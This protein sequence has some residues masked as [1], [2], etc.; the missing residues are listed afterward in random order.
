MRLSRSVT[1][2]FAV[3]IGWTFAVAGTA[4][5]GTAA[6][7]TVRAAGSPVSAPARHYYPPGGTVGTMQY[8]YNW[9]GY[10]SLPASGTSQTFSAVRAHWVVPSVTCLGDYPESVVQWVGLDG[11]LDGTV[12]QGGTQAYCNGTTPEYWAWWEMF[13]TNYIQDTFAVTPGD[14]VSASVTYAANTGNYTIVVQDVTSGQSLTEV[15]QCATNLTCRRS[16]A[17]WIVE[18]PSY[19]NTYANIPRW[20]ATSLLSD[21]AAITGSKAVGISS[22]NSYPITMV[23]HSGKTRALPHSLNSTGKGFADKWVRELW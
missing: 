18:S 9:S 23:N 20:S 21:D 12:E 15:E 5:A 13:P 11:W 3:I 2:A 14:N 19:D 4:V 22:L 7:G 10:V 6:A 1:V 8:S 16:S 17:E